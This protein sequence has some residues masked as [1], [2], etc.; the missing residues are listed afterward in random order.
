M[1]LFICPVCGGKLTKE[2]AYKCPSGHSFDTAAAGHVNLLLANQKHSKDPGDD[3]DMVMAR[4]IFLSADYYSP[5]RQKLCDLISR[6]SDGQPFRVTDI[7]CGEGYYT[8][9]IAALPNIRV[10]AFD[11]SKPAARK[12]ARRMRT[13]SSTAEVAVASA[14]SIPVADGGV[15]L[16]LNVFS[17]LHLPEISRVLTE[18]GYFVYVVP[19]AEH[20]WELK[21]LIYDTPYKNRETAPEYEGFEYIDKIPVRGEIHLPSNEHIRA[22]FTMTPYFWH[23]PKSFAARLDTVDTLDTK[24]GFDIHVYKKCSVDSGSLL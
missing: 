13:M 21:S 15:D 11:I 6:L 18:G 20:L 22:L 9:K 17:P 5:L 7:G 10:A 19:S 16:A 24:I 8:E 23:T 2:V 4:E 1:S 14:F 12:A 3:K